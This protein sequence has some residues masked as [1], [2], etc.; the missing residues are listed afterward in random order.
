MQQLIVHNLTAWLQRWRQSLWT[1]HGSIIHG[2]QDATRQRGRRFPQLSLHHHRQTNVNHVAGSCN[3][4]VI[5]YFNI[6]HHQ[7]ISKAQLNGRPHCA[8]V[9]CTNQLKM[10]PATVLNGCMTSLTVWGLLADCSRMEVQ[11]RWRLCRRSC[12]TCNVWT[13]MFFL[14]NFWN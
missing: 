7:G 1:V 5:V 6:G 9:P 10:S 3:V 2:R 8:L 4:D 11:L 13:K 14:E 12:F